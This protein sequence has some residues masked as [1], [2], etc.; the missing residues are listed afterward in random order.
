MKA[1]AIITCN[2]L[3]YFHQ[4]DQVHQ[5]EELWVILGILL[6]IS[7]D[8]YPVG[9]VL[10]SLLTTKNILT[11]KNKMFLLLMGTGELITK[12]WART[13]LVAQWIRICLPT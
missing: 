2:S 12:H 13:S 8:G 3:F 11:L 9:F 6:D 10:I 7:E 4:E 1:I 5:I